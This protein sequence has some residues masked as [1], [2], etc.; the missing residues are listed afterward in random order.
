MDKRKLLID[1]CEAFSLNS[2]FI[3][4]S[5]SNINNFDYK[6]RDNIFKNYEY[7]DI[8]DILLNLEENSLVH[9]EDQFSIRYLLFI[10]DKSLIKD[11][12]KY[13]LIGPFILDNQEDIISSINEENKYSNISISY[14]KKHLDELTKIKDEQALIMSLLSVLEFLNKKQIMLK[15]HSL[16][17]NTELLDNLK[18]PDYDKAKKIL[19]RYNLELELMDNIRNANYEGV[20]KILS[21]FNTLEMSSRYRG[22]IHKEK[23]ALSTLNTIC[24]VSLNDT[25]I[26]PV[27]IDELSYYLANKIENTTSLSELNILRDNIIKSYIDLVKEKSLDGYSYFIRDVINYINL[28]LSEPLS[29]SYLADKFSVDPKVLT[30]TFSKEVKSQLTKFINEKR[31]EKSVYYLINSNL[32]IENIAY[33]VGYM[34]DNYYRRVFKSIKNISPNEYRKKIILK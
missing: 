13:V 27:Y 10:L 14:I 11:N 6:F 30:T 28:N 21:N 24:R 23:Q 16:I 34:D 3:K 20:K 4:D 29:L 33:K 22:S 9:L 32:S 18:E 12:E 7:K 15:Y 26:H 19:N 17:N 31:V 1:L 25:F 2:V 8:I 5:F